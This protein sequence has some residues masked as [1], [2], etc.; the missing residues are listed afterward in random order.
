MNPHIVYILGLGHSGSTIIQYLLGGL[1]VVLGLGEVRHMAAGVGWGDSTDECSCGEAV[2]SC[3][4]WKNLKPSETETSR[5][6]YARVVLHVAEQY[7]T[8][9]HWI[10]TSKRTEGMQ[11]W[12]DLLSEGLI[13]SLRII[14]LVRDV[15]GWA[16]S[17]GIRQR[18]KGRVETPVLFS[19]NAWRKN[20]RRFL[21]FLEKNSPALQYCV[22]SYESLVFQNRRQLARLSDF[23]GVVYTESAVGSPLG[24]GTMHDVAGNPLKY[25]RE[26]RSSLIYDDWWQYQFGVNLLA[27][28]HYPAWRL[29][30]R[31]RSLGNPPD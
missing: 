20:Q 22:V 19:I 16:A 5:D 26:K 25:D 18:R 3:P 6:W 24:G 29:N 12:L 8:K 21:S 14:Y 9:T 1:D 15:R 10:D 17:H 7:P 30:A 4:V 11:P 2:A 28:C 27:L 23:L 13:A 31:L